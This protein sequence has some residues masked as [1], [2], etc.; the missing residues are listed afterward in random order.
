LTN[1]I[2]KLFRMAP[3]V[4]VAIHAKFGASSAVADL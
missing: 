2:Q 1:G 3:C 4:K